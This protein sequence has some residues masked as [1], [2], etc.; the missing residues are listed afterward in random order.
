MSVV[1]HR[2]RGLPVG[3]SK[4]AIAK[5][6][7]RG[8]VKRIGSD[9]S[10]RHTFD[11]VKGVLKQ[12]I[13]TV[14]KDAIMYTEYARRKTITVGDILYALKRQG[15]HVYGFDEGVVVKPKKT[16]VIP[17][18][19]RRITDY[20]IYVDGK[21]KANR[22]RQDGLWDEQRVDQLHRVYMEEK[23]EEAR[24][25]KHRYFKIYF[26]TRPRGRKAQE[27]LYKVYING[28]LLNNPS[29][30]NGLWLNRELTAKLRRFKETHRELGRGFVKLYL[31]NK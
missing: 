18:H 31:E 10:G 17:L 30:S 12:F 9:S 5:L 6:A 15:R 2:R 14:L 7:K 4:A 22:S 11:E 1:R 8:G 24:D 23:Q 26:R 16:K 21:H 27:A 13:E 19:R 20:E 25:G 29:R 3:P 28:R